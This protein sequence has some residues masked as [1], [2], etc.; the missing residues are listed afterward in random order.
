MTTILLIEDHAPL[1]EN[2]RELLALEGF[3]VLVADNGRAGL[4][5]AAQHHPALVLCDIMMP[6][7]DGYAV[8]ERLRAD[9]TTKAVPFIFLTAKGTPPDIRAGMNLGADDYLPKPVSRNDL[10]KA[11]RTRLERAKQQHQRF[12]P[13]F[14]DPKP[15]EK[16]G[17]SPRE[18]E[19]LLW[20]AQGKGNHEIAEILGLS[21]ATVKKHTIHIF[22]KLGVESRT[23]ASLRAL[24]ELA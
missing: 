22:E 12:A 18:A 17:I 23:A 20:V 9:A 14:E 5:L 16:L 11:V 2:L 15:L 19:V 13:N 3:H 1:R 24:E 21:V 7:M 6:G 10:L 8:L 4:Q